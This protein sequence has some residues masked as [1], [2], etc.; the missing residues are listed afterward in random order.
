MKALDSDREF[1]KKG[2]VLSDELIDGYLEL[3]E[4]ELA[5]FEQ[6]PQPI[7]FQTYYSA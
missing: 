2:D 1:P 6:A 3:K 7:E 4:E 5:A